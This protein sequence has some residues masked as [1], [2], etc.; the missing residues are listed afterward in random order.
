MN[1]LKCDNYWRTD[2]DEAKCDK[3]GCTETTEQKESEVKS[4]EP[5]RQN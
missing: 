3:C 1:C 4:N 2:I 5:V